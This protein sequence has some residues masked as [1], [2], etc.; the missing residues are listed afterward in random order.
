MNIRVHTC[1]GTKYARG[2]CSR[3]EKGSKVEM[4]EKEG[5]TANESR[6]S[7]SF[8]DDTRRDEEGDWSPGD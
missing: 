1:A 5:K 6:M 7:R 3:E 8:F 2:I 4:S